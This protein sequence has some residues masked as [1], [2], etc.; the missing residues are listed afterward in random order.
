MLR[1]L[2]CLSLPLGMPVDEV[3][4]R[5]DRCFV[6]WLRLHVAD[7]FRLNVKDARFLVIDP[8]D[9]VRRHD[10]ILHTQSRSFRESLVGGYFTGDPPGRGLRCTAQTRLSVPMRRILR[11]SRSRQTATSYAGIRG[12]FRS[13]A[14][15]GSEPKTPR[16]GTT[17]ACLW[18][19]RRRNVNYPMSV[20]APGMPSSHSSD[21]RLSTET[22]SYVIPT[23]I[24]SLCSWP[25]RVTLYE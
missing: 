18:I 23:R 10:G 4:R 12:W 8:D 22:F 20:A 7:R 3:L 16:D 6:N 11:A 17:Q 24:C 13:D 25:I 14:G 2:F 5:Q 21:L 9:G 15:I 1:L 19:R